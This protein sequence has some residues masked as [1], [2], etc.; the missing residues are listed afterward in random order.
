MDEVQNDQL[1]QS[2]TVL[3]DVVSRCCRN[4]RERSN[5]ATWKMTLVWEKRGGSMRWT[6]LQLL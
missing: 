1:M 2:H 3:K 5:H 6:Q 4:F